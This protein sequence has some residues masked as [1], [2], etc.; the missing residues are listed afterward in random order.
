VPRDEYWSVWEIMGST[1]GRTRGKMRDM[2]VGLPRDVVSLPLVLATVGSDGY[3]PATVAVWSVPDGDALTKWLDL[4]LDDGVDEHSFI[5][6]ASKLYKTVSGALNLEDSAYY[7]E[8]V[9]SNSAADL[10]ALEGPD[11]LLSEVLTPWQ[12]LAI[13]SASDLFALGK[14]EWDHMSTTGSA[15]VR[16]AVGTWKVKIP[17]LDIV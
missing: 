6:G 2:I 4:G 17:E 9:T 3:W 13:W 16:D 14:R 10:A 7:F 15:G 11:L 5:W 8:Y 12:G 1:D